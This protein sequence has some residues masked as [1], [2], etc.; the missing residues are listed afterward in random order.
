[1]DKNNVKEKTPTEKQ[2]VL[3]SSNYHSLIEREAIYVNGQ[4]FWTDDML[5]LKPKYWRNKPSE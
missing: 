1:M 2:V 5:P 3:V 4:Y